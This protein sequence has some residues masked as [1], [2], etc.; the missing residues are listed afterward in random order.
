MPSRPI[1]P[2]GKLSKA[3]ALSYVT[4]RVDIYG[5]HPERRPQEQSWFA[6]QAYFAGQPYFIEADGRIR[7][8]R[9][10]SANKQRFKANLIRPLVTRAL[11]KLESN[12]VSFRV[13]PKTGDRVDRHAAKIAERVHEH[14]RVETK[15]DKKREIAMLWAALCGSGYMKIGFDPLKGQPKRIYLSEQDRRIPD[16][17]PLY[18]DGL[19]QDREQRGLFDDIYPGEITCDVVSPYKIYWDPQIVWRE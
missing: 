12:N 13:A 4:D 7:V 10:L 3:K 11:A 2:H 1:Q 16:I 8:P 6:A 9:Q 5:E 19:R 17:A 18:D 14:L 15:F